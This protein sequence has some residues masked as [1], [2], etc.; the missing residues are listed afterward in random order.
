MKLVTIFE[1]PELDMLQYGVVVEGWKRV[2]QTGSGK[3]KLAQEF[4][5]EEIEKIKKVY[6]LFCWWYGRTGTPG[7][8]RMTLTEFE[9]TKRVCNFFGGY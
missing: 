4:T 3:R 7:E 2:M 8:H 5:S 6:K 1:K 9:F